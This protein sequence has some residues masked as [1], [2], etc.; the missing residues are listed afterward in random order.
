MPGDALPRSVAV[1]QRALAALGTS[2]RAVPLPHGAGAADPAAAA[3]A[4]QIPVPAFAR[5]DVFAADGR[6]LLVVAAALHRADPLALA[7]LRGAHQVA[8]ATPAQV[9]A[10]LGQPAAGAAPVG[11]PHPHDTLVDVELAQFP[12][13]WCAAGDPGWVFPT[14]YAELLRITAGEAA[15]VGGICSAGTA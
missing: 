8:H 12:T 13:V 11:H 9:E 10:W 7:A 3:A 6:P 2:S 15:E 5:T 14:S 4:L 1:V